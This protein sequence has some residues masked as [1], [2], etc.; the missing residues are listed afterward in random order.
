MVTLLTLSL[1]C[2]MLL[3]AAALGGFYALVKKPPVIHVDLGDIRLD[4][5]GSVDVS[6]MLPQPWTIQLRQL[7]P[8]EEIGPTPEAIPLDILEYIDE[9]SDEW[10]R[11]ARRKHARNLRAMLGGW[12]NVLAALK[13]EDGEN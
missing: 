13:K 4:M 7:A 5:V 1:V 6:Q 8:A 10:A 12:D 3:A 9:E 11:V 2:I